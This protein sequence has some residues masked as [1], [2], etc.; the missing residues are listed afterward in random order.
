MSAFVPP[1]ALTNE[2][3]RVQH[4]FTSKYGSA[5]ALKPPV[6][7]TFSPPVNL[8]EVAL[9]IYRSQL[10]FIA[11]KSTPFEIVLDGFDFFSRNRVVFIRIVENTSLIKMHEMFQ[12]ALT[13]EKSA[14]HPHI[15]I[16]YRKI[17]A[18]TF[19]MI[20]DDYQHQRFNGKFEVN[21]LHL[22]KYEGGQ[23]KTIETMPFNGSVLMT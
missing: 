14:Y 16:G 12:M 23:W 22:W 19:K 1:P 11:D 17:E 8:D 13:A 9:K 7:I 3:R 6:H 18:P 5:A 15:T 20:M 4:A 2:I 21:Q 10:K